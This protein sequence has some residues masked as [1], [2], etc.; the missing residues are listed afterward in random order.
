MIKYVKGNLLEDDA[1]ALVN[2]VNTIG[3]MGKGIALQF[4]E[5][6]PEN[7]KMYRQACKN[8]ELHVGEMFITEISLL[9]GNRF[10]I[11]FPTKTDWRKPS[12]YSYI[13]SGLKALRREIE[14]RKIH[15][16]AIPP[17]GSNNGGLDWNIVHQMILDELTD[18][19]CDIRI[20]QPSIQIAERLKQE[21]VKLT[22][23]RAMLLDMMHDMRRY[24][25]YCS[26]FAAE[27]IVYF[28]QRFG[29]SNIFKIRFEKY[30]YG[31]YSRGKIAHVLNYLNGSYVKGMNS[32]EAKP[33]ENIW[34]VDGTY[35]DIS[36][37][38]NKPEY[39]DHR[40]ILKKTKDF[41]CGFYSNYALEL[42]STIDFIV[43]ENAQSFN[44]QGLTIDEM[45]ARVNE[46]LQQ[47]SER[48][49]K[50]FAQDEHI[51]I[52]LNQLQQFNL[53]PS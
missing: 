20:Y 46:Y 49:V 52:A 35:E 39:E 16:I 12:D 15:S 10:I 42:L 1:Q 8:G 17:L 21:R 53:L 24:G 51:S 33:F 14:D 44:W 27:K 41:L 50:M 13:R 18:V 11:N 7:Y 32:M 19:D 48:K 3:V 6:F 38:L 34:L 4:K 28:L 37:F 5:A 47:W 2:T 9:D 25:E 40:I 36:S 26:V 30:Y 45:V 43:N 23:A 22:P 31:P 29:A